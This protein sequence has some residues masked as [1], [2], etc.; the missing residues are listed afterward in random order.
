MKKLNKVFVIVLSVFLTAAMFLSCASGGRPPGATWVFEDPALNTGG[1]ELATGENYMYRGSL[2][3]SRDDE[4]FGKGML[5]LD[6][7]FTQD[8]DQE[9]SEPKMK[10][11]FRSSINMKGITRFSFD[12]YYNPSLNTTEDGHFKSKVFSN[13]GSFLIN[14]NSEAIEG[15]EDAGNG[16]LKQRVE[17]LIMPS[18]GYIPDMRFSIAGYLTD[19]KGPVFFDD[20]RWE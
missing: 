19:Y 18:A 4:T 14:N 2:K 9:W 12:F 3:L 5:R 7:D 17:I 11:D 13:N 10:N 1:W 16:F 20:L 8:K 6:V 15:G